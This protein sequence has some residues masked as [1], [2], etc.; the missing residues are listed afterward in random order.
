MLSSSVVIHDFDL[1]WTILTPHETQAPLVIDADAVLSLPIT[2]QTL[3]TVSRYRGQV[4]Q[5]GCSIETLQPS[6][7]RCHEIDKAPD[8]AALEQ[9]SSITIFAALNH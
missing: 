2:T 6:A 9:C 8:M 3:Q 4:S 5:R 1:V 7:R